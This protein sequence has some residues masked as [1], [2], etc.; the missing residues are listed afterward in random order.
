M[1]AAKLL[2]S[3]AKKW[4]GIVQTV[5]LLI[6]IATLA[7]NKPESEFGLWQTALVVAV[8]VLLYRFGAIL[9]D[10][11]FDPLYGLK[12]SDEALKLWPKVAA[13][14]FSP[15]KWFVDQLP[16]TK[17]MVNDRK[18][19]TKVLRPRIDLNFITGDVTD[20]DCVGIYAAAKT[21]FEGSDQ[22]EDQVK[23][24]LELSKVIRSVICPIF[25]ILV[26]DVVNSIWKMAWFDRLLRA[27]VLNW[28]VWWEVSLTLLLLALVLYVWLRVLHMRAMYKLVSSSKY[29]ALPIECG[30]SNDDHEY[31]TVLPARHLRIGETIKQ[32]EGEH[33]PM[34]LLLR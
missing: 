24:P 21:L 1:D 14:L 18:E 25:A 31:R 7:F 26:F 10:L 33:P 23:P 22:W 12:P 29:I 11:V 8:A 5:S 2:E 15:I 27:P 6:M 16:G 4:P 9:D 19:A 3:K 32:K 13:K 17:D 20:K 28:L 34:F 30:I